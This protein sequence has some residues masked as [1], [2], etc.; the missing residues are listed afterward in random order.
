MIVA[1]ACGVILIK[2]MKSSDVDTT[3]QHIAEDIDGTS[4]EVKEQIPEVAALPD[5]QDDNANHTEVYVDSPNPLTD[6]DIRRLPDELRYDAATGEP[7]YPE[8]DGPEM[9]LSQEEINEINEL[10]ESESDG[11]ETTLSQAEIDEMNK[12]AAY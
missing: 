11:P 1:T 10:N 12:N 4:L 5:D 7:L 8:I 3:E 2:T 6:D 9:R